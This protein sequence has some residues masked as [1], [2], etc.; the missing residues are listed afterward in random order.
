MTQFLLLKTNRIDFQLWC[1][2]VSALFLEL[3]RTVLFLSSSHSDWG[4]SLQC[5][6]GPCLH[7]EVANGL[8]VVRLA[9]H[10]LLLSVDADVGFELIATTL[11]D[12]PMATVLPKLVLVRRWQRLES[13]VR[14]IT[15]VKALT[16][17]CALSSNTDPFQQQHKFTLAGTLDH[18]HGFR[19]AGLSWE[20]LATVIAL[21]WHQRRHQTIHDV[22]S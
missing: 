8:P 16:L 5:N 14:D 4:W 13:L 17:S 15:G 20:V 10:N 22:G 18:R 19:Q 6:G 11:A 7:G 21:F 9:T 12:K 2:R 3:A 1:Y